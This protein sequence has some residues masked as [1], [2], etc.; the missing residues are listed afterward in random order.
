MKILYFMFPLK[1]KIKNSFFIIKHVFLIFFVLKKRKTILGNNYQIDVS[2][3]Q[4]LLSQR[5][6]RLKRKKKKKENN[7]I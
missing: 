7:N 4:L 3:F 2:F 6:K 1:Q 5:T